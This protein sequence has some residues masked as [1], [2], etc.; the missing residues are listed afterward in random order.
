MKYQEKYPRK[1]QQGSYQLEVQLQW[2]DFFRLTAVV[3]KNQLFARDGLGQMDKRGRLTARTFAKR[4]PTEEQWEK[5]KRWMNGTTGIPYIDAGMREL[6]NT[7]YMGNRLRQNTASY[8]MHDLECPDWRIGAEYFQSKLI[9][10]D[11]TSNWMGWQYIAGVS[12]D[13]KH[14]KRYPV[15]KQALTYDETGFFA[16]RWCPELSL[17]PE[18]EIH[19]PFL[20]TEE[21]QEVYSFKLG[22]TYPMPA[23]KPWRIPSEIDRPTELPKAAPEPRQRR[24][25]KLEEEVEELV[26]ASEAEEAEEAAQRESETERFFVEAEE[27]IDDEDD[28]LAELLAMDDGNKNEDDPSAQLDDDEEGTVVENAVDADLDRGDDSANNTAIIDGDDDD[29][30]DDFDRD[31]D[32]DE[33]FDEDFDEDLDEDEEDDEHLTTSSETDD[34]PKR[35]VADVPVKAAD[36]TPFW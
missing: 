23:V 5:I 11:V 26:A 31:E 36:K 2:R 34:R 1:Q 19:V 10:H 25:P 4:E 30:D 15:V 33:D 21:E 24:R 20:L 13:P 27:H 7:G 16:R 17:V 32:L 6:N 18:P 12:N 29:D 22:D 8:L 14:G 3:Y 35:Q 9:D 28:F